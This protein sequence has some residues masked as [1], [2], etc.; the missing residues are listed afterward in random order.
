MRLSTGEILMIA[1]VAVLLFGA[2]RLP[3][4]GKGLGQGMRSFRDALKGADEPHTPEVAAKKDEGA[5][6]KVG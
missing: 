1:F 3:E 2:K 4:L 5:D 6:K